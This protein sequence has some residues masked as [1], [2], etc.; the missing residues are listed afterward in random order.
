MRQRILAAIILC[1]S[2]ATSDAALLGRAPL[3]PGGTDYQAYYDDVLGIT[4]LADAN[5]AETSGFHDNHL[6]SWY[7]ANGFIAELNNTSHLGIET[8]RLPSM[9][10]N[11]DEYVVKCSVATDAE[12]RDNE[13]GYMSVIYAAASVSPLVFE[14]VFFNYWSSTD[15][16]A[17]NVDWPGGATCNSGAEGQ[18]AWR[19]GFG[20]DS[21]NYV[22]KTYGEPYDSAELGY[23]VWAVAS[24]DI[25][26]VPIP[27][28][29]WLLASAVGLL[30]WLKR[31]VTP[32]AS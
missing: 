5:F 20:F 16:D 24:G 8:W 27:A 1:L 13:L 31:R 12:C 2:A 15:Y 25:A 18:C 22:R 21:Q 3:T 30:A 23:S 32:C 29:A 7:E 4:W 10:V 6:L 11:A 9:D 14:N 28:A 26:V 19:Q 17:D